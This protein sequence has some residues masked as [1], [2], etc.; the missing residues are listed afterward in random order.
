M[1]WVALE[2][3]KRITA[4]DAVKSSQYLCPE[5]FCTVRM[6]SGPHRRPHYYHVSKNFLCRQQKKT[7]FH[8][9]T[10]LAIQ[11]KIPEA[12]LEFS[13][14]SI[15]RIADVFW[16]E[17]KFVFEIQ[18]SNISYAE[19]KKRTEDYNSLGIQVIWI[20]H[21]RRY[22]R[23]RLSSAELFL[24]ERDHYFSSI[25]SKGFCIIYDQ[26]CLTTGAKRN[27]KGVKL[28]I[29]LSKPYWMNEIS[30]INDWPKQAISRMN[31]RKIGFQGDL[32]DRIR[33]TSP[34]TWKRMKE[35]ELPKKDRFVSRIQK[36]WD[37]IKGI[38]SC[39]LHA[40]LE[41]NSI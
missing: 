13:F 17:K 1:Q 12:I 36:Q 3:G 21:D 22:N 5:C 31:T 16:P 25:D 34:T 40:L 28:P 30:K 19:I 7:P 11:K 33:E 6:R 8:F 32:I 29:D 26:F 23:K 15:H 18:C 10:Q 2:D 24:Q 35:L 39:F 4:E 37:M 27:F 38:Y 9:E 20:L 14:P 41:K